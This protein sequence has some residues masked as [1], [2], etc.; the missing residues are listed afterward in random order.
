MK[1]HILSD[2]HLEFSNLSVPET[3]ASVVVLAGDIWI[4]EAGIGW[5]RETFPD[6]EII[7]LAGNHEFYGQQ[8]PE[9]LAR[10]RIAAREAGVHFLD[11]D[12]VVIGGVRFLGCTLWT[13][14]ELFGAEVKPQAIREGQKFLNDFRLVH[15]GNEVFS[16]MDSIRLHQESLA[17]LQSELQRPFDGKTVVVS[18]HSPSEK[19][20]AERFKD[21]TLS[22]CFASRLDYLFG[23]PVDLWIHGHTHDN[24]DYEIMG[25]RVICNPRGYVRFSTGPEN[26]DFDPVLVVEI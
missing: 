3:D 10:L 15:E 7:Y 18:H 9:M 1:L 17:W 22:A 19:S 11:N 25:T 23:P 26:L 8:R 6:K 20:I 2:L 24:L 12:E 5:A 4:G 16:P 21:S 14:F 13:D